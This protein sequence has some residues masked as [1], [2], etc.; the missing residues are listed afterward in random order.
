[1]F[2]LGRFFKVATVG[3]G[4]AIFGTSGNSFGSGFQQRLSLERTG[5]FAS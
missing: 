3:L 4:G 2:L 1:M 5:M